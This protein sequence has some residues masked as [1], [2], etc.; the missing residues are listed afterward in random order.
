[1]LLLCESWILDLILD[2]RFWG[3]DFWL[4][5]FG[6]WNFEFGILDLGT[7]GTSQNM[8]RMCQ[9]QQ[10]GPHSLLFYAILAFPSLQPCDWLHWNLQSN[11]ILLFNAFLGKNSSIQPSSHPNFSTKSDPKVAATTRALQNQK[12]RGSHY[13]IRTPLQNQDPDQIS[14][15]HQQHQNPKNKAL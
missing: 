1:M 15:Y 5:D 9:P 4:L 3:L 7:F 13:K 14:K 10:C 2:L 11:W 6:V 8:K 12:P